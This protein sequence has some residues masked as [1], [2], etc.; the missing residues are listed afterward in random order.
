[1]SYQHRTSE[2]THHW[3]AKNT[4]TYS[5]GCT[6]TDH[7]YISHECIHTH[8]NIT[9]TKIRVNL[10]TIFDGAMGQ[11]QPSNMNVHIHT[12][13]YTHMQRSYLTWSLGLTGLWANNLL[14]NTNAH[15]H[16]HTHTYIHT[17]TYAHTHTHTHTHINTQTYTRMQRLYLTWELGL[18]GLWANIQLSKTNAHTHTHTHTHTQT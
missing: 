4:V 17:H 3:V 2:S 15:T 18:T 11:Q 10:C 16:T 5:N 13:T 9:H 7:K 1:M 14:S 12:Q 8:R 6:Q